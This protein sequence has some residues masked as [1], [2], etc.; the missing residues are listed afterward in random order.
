MLM[1]WLR[2]LISVNLIFYGLALKQLS[3]FMADPQPQPKQQKR[4]RQ[5]S[6]EWGFVTW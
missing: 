1:W 3:L 2:S 4:M 6:A 5:E